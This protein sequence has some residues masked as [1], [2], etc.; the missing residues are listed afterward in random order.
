MLLDPC[1]RFGLCHSPERLGCST[2]LC[3]QEC[4]SFLLRPQRRRHLLGGRIPSFQGFGT[5]HVQDAFWFVGSR[6]HGLFGNLCLLLFPNFPPS[7]T[8]WS[9]CRRIVGQ[10][11]LRSW[12]L[13]RSSCLG[14]SCCFLDPTQERNVNKFDYTSPFLT[15]QL[16]YLSW[17]EDDVRFHLTF[18]DRGTKYWFHTTC[19]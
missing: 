11:V 1:R 18:L 8:T 6:L 2:C 17:F 7:T 16:P 10:V 9:H 15:T 14:N 3:S 12:K 5:S 4:W 19:R 13:W